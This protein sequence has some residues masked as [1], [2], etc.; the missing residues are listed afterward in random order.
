MKVVVTG[1]AG[2]VGSHLVDALVERGED[3]IVLDNLRRGSVQNLRSHLSAGRVRLLDDDV[4][5]LE[6]VLRAADGAEVV[7]HLAAQSNVMGAL[8]DVDY[9]F[10]TNV[11]GTFN[12]LKAAS[13]VGVRRVVFTSSREVY[14]EPRSVPVR[15]SDPLA[16]KNPY[17]AS[18]IAGE[19]YCRV[20]GSIGNIECQVLRLANVY[21]PRDYGRVIPLW[22]DRALRGEPL[23]LHGGDQVLDFVWI[24]RAVEAML[25]AANCREQ[26]A[27]N[28]GSGVGIPLPELAQRIIAMTG[29]HSTVRR[30][31]SR[32][33]EVVRFVADVSRMREV[34]GVTPDEDPLAGLATMLESQQPTVH[35]K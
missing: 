25:A 7:Y 9:S 12:V 31:P 11:V 15:E 14:G 4:R 8:Q 6:S 35:S 10:T 16:A 23:D 3:V 30:L 33:P 2:F 34:L 32:S 26:D 22:L 19:A 20:W 24:A 5:D 1:G 13:E 17:G 27:V 18:K 29:G 28:V 21:G